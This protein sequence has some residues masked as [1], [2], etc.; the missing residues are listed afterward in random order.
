LD[1]SVVCTK[2]VEEDNMMDSMPLDTA[3]PIET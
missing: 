2:V 3:I 1:R